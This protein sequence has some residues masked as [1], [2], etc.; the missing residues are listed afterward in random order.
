[1]V[2]MLVM[3]DCVFTL[4][5]VFTMV[6]D[7]STVHVEKVYSSLYTLILAY[8]NENICCTY[9]VIMWLQ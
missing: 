3:L 9:N 1:M 5:L 2:I 7:Y 8:Y 6:R 4:S